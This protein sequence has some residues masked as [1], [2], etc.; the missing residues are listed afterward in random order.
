MLVIRVCFHLFHL[1]LFLFR[2][3]LI[4]AVVF[5]LNHEGFVCIL[6]KSFEFL[7]FVG[8]EKFIC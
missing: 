2:F 6:S 7:Q 3:F 1:Y 8:V 5:I 4:L